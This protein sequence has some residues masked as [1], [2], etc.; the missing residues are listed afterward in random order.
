MNIKFIIPSLLFAFVLITSGCSKSAED[1]L[2][3][4]AWVITSLKGAQGG[5]TVDIFALTEACTKDDETTFNENGTVTVDEGASKCNSTDPQTYDGGTW[6]LSEDEKTLSMTSDGTTINWTLTK[7]ETDLLEATAS[8]VD[9]TDLSVTV[10][11]ATWAK[12]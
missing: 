1:K 8:V 3:G 11:T 2:T 10:I 6:V 9:P 7:L 4:H 12:P 5:F